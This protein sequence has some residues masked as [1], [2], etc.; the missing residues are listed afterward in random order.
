M[1]VDTRTGKVRITPPAQGIDNVDLQGARTGISAS[2]VGPDFSIIAGDVVELTASNY[3]ASDVG[4]FQ[5]GKIRVEFDVNITNRLASVQLITPTFP[6]PPPGTD[7]ILLFPFETVVTTTTGGV[8][9]GGDGTDV[10]IEQPNRGQVAASVD[11][12]GAPFNFFNDTGCGAGSNDCY[13]YQSFAQP[14][15][16][17]ATSEAQRVGFDIDPTVA[18]FRARLIVAADLQN[19]GAAPTGTV[20]GNVSSPQRGALPAVQ[21]TVN[22]GGFAGTTDANGAYSIPNVT[23]GSKTVSLANLPAGCTNPGSQTTTVTNGGTSTVNFTVQCSV[24]SGAITGTVTRSDNGAVLAGVSVTATPTGG[25]ATAPASTNASGV[26]L[27]SSVPVASGTGDLALSNLP[28]SCTSP[29]N[30]PYSGLTQ[31]GTV[32]VDVVVPCTPPPQGYQLTN[33]WGTVTGGQ[34][35]L[36]VA[37]DMSTYDDAAIPGSDDVFSIAGSTTFNPQILTFVSCSNVAGSGLANIAA[38]P[39]VTPGVIYW[40]N[41]TAAPPATG[42]QGIMTCTFTVVATGSVTTQTV[43]TEVVSANETDLIPHIVINEGTRS[44]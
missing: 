39:N 16:P 22:T 35:T 7:G 21:V 13:R 28:A 17:G 10:I 3:S 12:D 30:I 15:A 26:Y 31:N 36:T 34:V 14:L 25:S 41:F 40:G 19:A 11:W 18:N 1:D 42:M 44:F 32:T 27:L 23:T 43:L 29:G 24:P 4:Q 2:V 20:M 37:I 5:P 8:G 6:V 9:V 33:T 38:N